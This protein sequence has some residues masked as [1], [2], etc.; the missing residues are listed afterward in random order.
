MGRNNC[1]WLLTFGLL[2]LITWLDSFLQ[3]DRLLVGPGCFVK[4]RGD[5]EFV[6]SQNNLKNDFKELWKISEDFQRIL[7]N[8]QNSQNA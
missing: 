7:E 6:N 1:Q 5:Y 2:L 3:S 8:L 4:D